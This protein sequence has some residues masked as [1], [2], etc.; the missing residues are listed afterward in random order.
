[1]Q[2]HLR[3]KIDSYTIKEHRVGTGKHKKIDTG[4]DLQILH[5]V[6]VFQA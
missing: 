5:L 4:S 3:I 2:L 1:M 6:L